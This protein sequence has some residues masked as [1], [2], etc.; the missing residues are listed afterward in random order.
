MNIGDT[1]VLKWSNVRPDLVNS[2]LTIR[3][4]K[5]TNLAILDF[6]DIYGVDTYAIVEDMNFRVAEEQME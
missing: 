1:F 4:Q 3:E 5:N 2:K 6:A